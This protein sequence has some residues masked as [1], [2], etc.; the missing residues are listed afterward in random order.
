VSSTP[1]VDAGSQ[2][3]QALR[4][5]E[6]MQAKLDAVTRARTEPIAIIGIG[7]RFPG[8][9]T[10]PETFWKMLR[11]GV[12]AVREVPPDRWDIDALYDT[13]P[14]APG[15]MYTRWSGFLDDVDRFDPAFFGISPREAVSMDPQQRL[16]LEVAWEALE[17]AAY[18]P[19]R[20]SSSQTGVYVGAC[21]SDYAR[22]QFADLRTIEVYAG[23]GSAHSILANR[24][25]YLLDLHGPSMAIDTACSSSLVAVHLA[26]QA[27]RSGECQVA[28]AGGVNLI[29]SPEPTIIFCKARMMASDGRCKTFD[30][31]ADGYV[32]GEGCGVVVLKRL[33][34]ARADGDPIWAVIR[35]SAVNQDGR[36]NGLAAPNLLA[37]QRVIEQALANANV[38]PHQVG[39]VEAHGTGTALGDPIEVA[40]L[41]ETYGSRAPGAGPCLLGSVKTNIGHLEAAAGIAGLIKAV[42][43][44]RHHEIP[45]HLHFRT[46]NPNIALQETRFVIPAERCSWPEDSVSRLAAVSSFGFGGTNAHVILDAAPAEPELK[47]TPADRPAAD[48]P[49]QVLTLSARTPVALTELA[50][51]FERYLKDA[52][53]AWA[54]ICA[55]A[56]LGRT[57]FPHRLALVASS[58]TEASVQLAAFAAG[59]PSPDLVTSQI[60]GDRLRVAFLFSGQGSQYAGMGRQLYETEPVFRDALD[61]CAAVL[62]P[63]LDRPLL[64]V[65]FGPAADDAL[66]RTVYGQPALFALE[67]ALAQLWIAWGL[68]PDC[69]LG[70]SLGELVAACVSG[71][72]SLEDGL[73]LV[74]ARGRLTERHALRGSMAAV[75]AD[76]GCV[77]Q[78]L[79]GVAPD[80]AVAAE[81]SASETVIGGAS[82]DVAA[83]LAAAEARGVRVRT[84]PGSLAFHS[85]LMEPVLAPFA[86]AAAAVQYGPARIPIVSN[87]SGR[88]AAPD[89]L[90]HADYWV[91]QLREPVRFSDALQTLLDRD[92][93]ALLEIGPKPVLLNIHRHACPDTAAIGL[94][95]LRQGV[96][97]T[98]G[99]LRSLARYYVT[100]GR[101]NWK[102]VDQEHR[103]QRVALP[104][105]PFQRSRYWIDRAPVVPDATFY[106]VQWREQP[107][108]RPP[109]P[110]ADIRWIVVQDRQGV[111]DALA[112][113]LAREG[114]DVALIDGPSSPARVGEQLEARN[115]SEIPCVVLDL[116][117]LDLGLDPPGSGPDLIATATRRGGS[118]LQLVRSVVE[119]DAAARIWLVT[120]G[121]QMVD[122]DAMLPAL[123]QAPV[124]GVGRVLAHEHP[125]NWGGLIDL[126]P[127]AHPADAAKMLAALVLGSEGEDQWIVRGDRCY[128][129]RLTRYAPEAGA[130]TLDTTGVYLISGGLGEMGLCMADWLVSR[131]ARHL[132]LVG[133]RA[134]EEPAQ[135][136]VER[137]RQSGADVHIFEADV[138]DPLDVQRVL[139][140]IDAGPAP[141]RGVIHCAGVL[142]DG[143]ILRQDESR[144]GRVLAPKVGGAWELH[145][146]TAGSNLQ[147][148]VLCSSAAGI[149][150]SPGQS[151]YAA[152]NVALDA[153]AIWRRASGLP[154]LSVQWGPWS[155]GMG[156]FRR[157]VAGLQNLT[158]HA[159]VALLERLLV[160]PVADV[161]AM[162]VNWSEL[163]RQNPLS[164]EIPL[165]AELTAA[166]RRT[167]ASLTFHPEEPLHADRRVPVLDL[168]SAASTDDRPALIRAYLEQRI[169]TVL[170][171]SEPI[172]DRQNILELGMDSLMVVE[173]LNDC[174][175]DLR[176]ALYPREMYAL[177]GFG[178]LV[179]YVAGAFE[180]SHGGG[181]QVQE[182]EPAVPA[183]AAVVSSTG[184]RRVTHRNRSM[185]FLLSS[186]RSGSTLLRVMLAGHPAL[187]SPPELHLLAYDSMKS[188]SLALAP[189]YLTEGLQR[190]LMEL[191]H[192]DASTAESALRTMID[193]DRPVQ[194]VYAMLQDLAGERILVDKSPTYGAR[195][196]MLHRAEALFEQPR[197]I[198]LVRHP[199]AVIE[200][201][202]RNRMDKVVGIDTRDPIALADQ[203]WTTINGNIRRFLRDIEPERQHLVRYE[204][205]VT[206]PVG[207]SR[208]L[209]EFL[210]IPF[211]PAL[212]EPYDGDRMTDGVHARS[213]PIG[214]PGFLSH[215]NIDPALADAWRTVEL[216]RGISQ[217]GRELAHVFGYAIASRDDHVAAVDEMQ[218]IWLDVGGRRLCLC[219]WGPE[220]GPAILCL[221][222]ALEHGASWELVARP[223]AERGFRVVAPDFRGHG[224]S[225]HVGRGG[226]YHLIDFLADADA[227]ARSLARPFRLVG[228]SMGAAIAAMYAS[229]RP[230]PVA[231]LVLVEPPL[232]ALPRDISLADQLAVQ[233]DHLATP[234]QHPVFD[235]VAAAARRLRAAVPSLPSSLAQRAAARLTEP[236]AGGVRWRWDPQLRTRAGVV[237]D[238][239]AMPPEAYAEVLA[240]ITAP[241][242][243]VYGDLSTLGSEGAGNG[244][245]PALRDAQRVVLRGGHHLHF[246][247]PDDLAAVIAESPVAC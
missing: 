214:D 141:L 27:L 22:H 73:R 26:C 178:A 3:K 13:D 211:D 16:L 171:R 66:Q 200:S 130:P 125:A 83:A 123:Q 131:G 220:S 198:H 242:T 191:M 76:S 221:H 234:R 90:S 68:E 111:A 45:P 95:S 188:W 223:L 105:Y 169:N 229:A 149:L 109:R 25:S 9:G 11:N 201:F 153:L 114:A 94:P 164:A 99:V 61:R 179:E 21:S 129:A 134:P 147:F 119:R 115:D 175:R 112:E 121:A 183:M 92:V 65:L 194:Q 51:R 215:G 225:D 189:S 137:L 103:R 35:G 154:A 124:W 40:A 28:L 210:H 195:L 126:D 108:R 38:E 1:H 102:A 161:A 85:S 4:A 107:Q 236:C 230:A 30:A 222:G 186:P 110:A 101:V 104:T 19:E 69:L 180:R 219:A 235:D 36:S 167:T 82:A 60:A 117:S 239:A 56:C 58:A 136:H 139:D 146:R 39:Y 205:L 197:Y 224:R 237:L 113:Q 17:H 174:R 166:T 148:F 228:H 187:F 162:Q 157:P 208:R 7:C 91:R 81:N 142:E 204:D 132:V 67:W 80:V 89:E 240:R 192:A 57:H 29:L 233:L 77:R 44:L 50:G 160:A 243:L 75:F 206:D 202:V 42:L 116:A 181:R 63:L 143:V 8:G 184:V 46:L 140:S 128:A 18:T 133:R 49:D 151:T 246:D 118:V 168:L 96:E 159:G 122:G 196:D 79:E 209:C 217:S 20:L 10:G 31:R 216:P 163:L 41:A 15:K 87:R 165:L 98:R 32:R 62:D 158:P 72:F 70:H 156:R 93:H 135:A 144:L 226:S 193:E 6:K 227:V 244:V 37:Q 100:G 71:V 55:T 106:R 199:H 190:A 185:V 84:L 86:A 120:R 97:D 34:D 207:V 241:T 155:V 231:G 176:I 238:G 33:S 127:A 5:L 152:A 138:A 177:P 232:S 212:L 145:A 172:D 245:V 213:L 59:Q 203:A 52:D 88:V 218:E 48:R 54:D 182:S 173:V 64:E 78:L 150:G 43:C 2:V 47:R 23:T 247:A 24:L 170:R 74:E 14:D 53:A 12:D